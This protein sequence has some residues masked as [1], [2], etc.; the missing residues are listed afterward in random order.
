[1]RKGRAAVAALVLVLSGIATFVAL[2]Q[3]DAASATVD[4]TDA[5]LS[6]ASVSIN[7]GESVTWVNKTDHE[8]TLTSSQFNGQAF[9]AT[10]TNRFDQHGDYSYTVTPGD[11]HGVVH[12]AGD[13][14]TTAPP[15][16][17]AAPNTEPTSTNST[18]RTTGAAHT[19]VTTAKG[20]PT[21][22]GPTVPLAT[23]PGAP[24]T[25]RST[26]AGPPTT[27]GEFAIGHATSNNKGAIII[28]VAAAAAAIGVGGYL[29]YRRRLRSPR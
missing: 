14:P 15:P 29:A 13:A 22:V 26:V 10:F 3:A 4:I 8:V 5:G 25:T 16:T 20:T 12:V 7:G 17:T 27:G 9:S 6:A 24:T 28:L 23:V 21:S 2:P 18:T 1:M 19:T 11:F